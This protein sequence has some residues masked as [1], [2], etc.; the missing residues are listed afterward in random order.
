LVV[1]PRYEYYLGFDL[2]S[3]DTEA[4]SFSVSSWRGSD[5]V[6][7]SIISSTGSVLVD[8]GRVSQYS[9]NYTA[10][11]PGRYYLRFDNTY[12]F[13][14]TKTISLSYSTLPP[15]VGIE[16][17]QWTGNVITGYLSNYGASNV[18]T[19]STQVS[20]NGEAVRSLGGTCGEGPVGSDASCTFSVT[21]PNGNW[22]SGTPYVLKL[23]TPSGAFSFP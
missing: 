14:T 11:F 13:F 4:F 12:S 15:T 17:Y 21:V 3:G 6:G 8:V 2:K 10:V 5:D 18:D 9:G 22:T 20:L 7:L 16:E 19:N 23:V 1:P